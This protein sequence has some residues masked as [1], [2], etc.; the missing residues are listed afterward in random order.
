MHYFIWSTSITQLVGV[1]FCISLCSQS[2]VE[3]PI[4]KVLGNAWLVNE[5]AVLCMNFI[6]EYYNR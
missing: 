3:S 1:R 6:F 2:P 5:E 4:H